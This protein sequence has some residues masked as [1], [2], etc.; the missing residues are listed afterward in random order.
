MRS[1]ENRS[2]YGKYNPIPVHIASSREDFS[3][4]ATRLV[5]PVES[6]VGNLVGILQER[7]KA[8]GI[9]GSKP[10]APPETPPASEKYFTEEI[11]G[12]HDLPPIMGR[13]VVQEGRLM[14]KYQSG[15]Q[16]L[17]VYIYIYTYIYIRRN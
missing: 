14:T 13:G 5:P 6:C 4:I 10:R 15:L 8:P 11:K 2:F 9:M 16:A 17:G 12:A 3:R 1:V 7:L